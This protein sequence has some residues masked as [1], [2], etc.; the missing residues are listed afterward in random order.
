[1]A[2]G[3]LGIPPWH[4]WGNSETKT[5]DSELLDPH[6]AAPPPNPP[7]NQL[8]RITYGRPENWRFL[9][10]AKTLDA[11]AGALLDLPEVVVW[12][13][14]IVGVGRAQ[15]E[16]TKFE[17]FSFLLTDA[18]VAPFNFNPHLKFSSSVRSPFR[19][20]ATPRAPDDVRE[21]IDHLPAQDIQ[22]QFQVLVGRA[23]P[24]SPGARVTVEVGA[25]W[26]PNVHIRPEWMSRVGVFPGGEA[27]GK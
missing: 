26:S 19:S 16:L 20:D 5:Y 27:S 24:P 21:V 12:F 8:I 3:G 15:V 17:Q 10:W 25:L 14:V 23:I 11:S 2:Q 9:F 4:M 7:Q 13:N 18:V 22:V 6:S 1:M